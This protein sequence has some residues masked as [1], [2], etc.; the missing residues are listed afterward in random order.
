MRTRVL[1]EVLWQGEEPISA[2][3]RER[4]RRRRDSG[5]N[6]EDGSRVLELERFREM[7]ATDTPSGK[8]GHGA[9]S[10][11][12]RGCMEKETWHSKGI[13]SFYSKT[14]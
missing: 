9:L 13:L 12:H 3:G 8:A 14:K 4:R 7:V 6:L 1:G 11:S 5:E 2:A 10:P